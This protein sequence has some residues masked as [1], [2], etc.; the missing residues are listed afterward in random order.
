[1]LLGILNSQA[2]GGGGVLAYDLLETTTLGSSASSVTFSGLG[3]YSDYAHLQIRYVART[4][5]ADTDRDLHLTFNGDSGANYARHY[6]EGNGSSVSSQSATSRNRIEFNTGISGANAA[7]SIFGSGVIDV[8]DAFSSNKNTTT[9]A[10]YAPFSVNR[11]FFHSGLWV[12]TSSITSMA[13]E[14]AFGDFISGSRF[15][16]YGI[17]GA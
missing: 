13:F 16:L 8:L 17:K 11:L 9:R 10:L 3:S 1:M 6:L 2:A 7:S 14:P 5:N 4:S 15:S 12:N